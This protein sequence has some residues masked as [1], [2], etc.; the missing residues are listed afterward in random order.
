MSKLELSI[1]SMF[2]LAILQ[3]HKANQVS[4]SVDWFWVLGQVLVQVWLSEFSRL[5]SMAEDPT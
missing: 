1:S 4:T 2:N 3:I 5:F